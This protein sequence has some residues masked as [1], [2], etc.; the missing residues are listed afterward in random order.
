MMLHLGGFEDANDAEAGFAVRAAAVVA[1][2]RCGR[3]MAFCHRG[4]GPRG[5]EYDRD[6]GSFRGW[7][8]SVVGRKLQASAWPSASNRN[9]VGVLEPTIW[10]TV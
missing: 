7:L 10:W 6:R 4:S 5:L 8:F 9:V 2:S 3:P 1:E